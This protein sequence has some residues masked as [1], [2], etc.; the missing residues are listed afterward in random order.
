MAELTPEQVGL[1]LSLVRTSYRKKVRGE[2]SLRRKLGKEYDPAEHLKKLRFHETLYQALG[3]D[4]TNL[5]M[6]ASLT[7]VESS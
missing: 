4:P 3:G 6:Q 5:V 2:A 1:L 7:A